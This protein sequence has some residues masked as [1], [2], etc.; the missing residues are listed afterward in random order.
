L[1]PLGRNEI[2]MLTAIKLLHTL[3]WAFMVA[4]IAALPVLAVL[5][6][7]RWAAILSGIVLVECGVVAVNGGRCPL[8]DLAARFTNDRAANFDIYLPNWLAQHNKLIFGLLFVAGEL[9]VLG[10][11]LAERRAAAQGT[12]AK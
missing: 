1:R 11:W 3:I 7:F 5:R 2:E 10:Y 8:T 12:A 9:V 6:R 4:C